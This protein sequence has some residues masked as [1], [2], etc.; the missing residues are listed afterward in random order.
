[1]SKKLILTLPNEMYAEVLKS[2][3]KLN[4]SVLDYIRYLITKEKEEKVN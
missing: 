3:S 1:V 2:A 4:I